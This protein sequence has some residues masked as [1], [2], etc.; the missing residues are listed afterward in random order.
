MHVLS[1]F[2]GVESHFKISLLKTENSTS[3]YHEFSLFRMRFHFKEF[4]KYRLIQG[5]MEIFCEMVW[6]IKRKKKFLWT[7]ILFW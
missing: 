2:F 1:K 7:Y 4:R 5:E 6:I 3:L